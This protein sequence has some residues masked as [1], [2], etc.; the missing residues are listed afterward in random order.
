MRRQT[1]G[2]K[3]KHGVLRTVKSDRMERWKEH[4][5][6]IL[7]RDAPIDPITEEEIEEAE[8]LE[9]ID[10]GRWRISEVRSALK[11][12]RSGKAAGVDQ[13]RDELLKSDLEITASRLE[14]LV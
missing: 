12:T 5:S 1:V 2:V 8:E 9:D 7:N 11:R 10:T 13:V 4:F 14:D 6:E 3:G